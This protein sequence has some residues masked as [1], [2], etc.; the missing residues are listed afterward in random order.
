MNRETWIDPSVLDL[1]DYFIKFLKQSS[2]LEA[3]RHSA[4]EISPT[5]PEHEDSL[6]C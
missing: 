3:D 5:V 1:F 2:S 6:P 4:V